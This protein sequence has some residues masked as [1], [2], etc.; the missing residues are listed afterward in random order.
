MVATWRRKSS[1]SSSCESLV[2]EDNA[3]SVKS[4]NSSPS[5]LSNY[6]R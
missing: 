3:T 6:A 2:K 1:D 4:V 5:S